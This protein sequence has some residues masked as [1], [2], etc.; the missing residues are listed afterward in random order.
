MPGNTFGQIFCLTT[1]GE[2]HGP[3]VG[4]VVVTQS[5]DTVDYNRAFREIA[6]R[7]VTRPSLPDMFGAAFVRI[8]SRAWIDSSTT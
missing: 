4:C 8:L 5:G 1:W 2:S 6:E 7:C 3:A